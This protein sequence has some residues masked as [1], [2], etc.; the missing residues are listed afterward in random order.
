MNQFNGLLQGYAMAV[1]F[2]ELENARGY[3]VL[4]DEMYAAA[5]RGDDGGHTD[6]AE[7]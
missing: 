4:L 1:E 6:Q 2:D 7:S 5:L 3:A